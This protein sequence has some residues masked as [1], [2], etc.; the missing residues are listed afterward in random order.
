MND[1]PLLQ[2]SPLPESGAGIDAELADILERYL[3]A[4]E[5]GV[6]PSREEFLAQHPGRVTELNRYLPWIELLYQAKPRDDASARI[7]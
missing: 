6:A 2:V 3:T 1:A 5:Q 4:L 7:P